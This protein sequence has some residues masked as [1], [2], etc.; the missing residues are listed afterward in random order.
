MTDQR[1]GHRVDAEWD[2]TGWWVVTV[3]DVPG[4]ITQTRRLDQVAT[5]A[6][7]II[8]IQTGRTVDQARLIVIPRLPGAA[9]DAAAEARALRDQ[10]QQLREQASERTR[11]AVDLLSERGFTVRDIGTLIGIT[12]QRAHQLV[13]GR[14]ASARS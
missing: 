11:I 6:A 10:A 2:E 12:Y 14:R 13:A 9:G 5:D 3:P 4:A 7:E 1:S 8:E